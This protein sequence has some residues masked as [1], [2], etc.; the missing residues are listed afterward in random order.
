[1]DEALT[2]NLT[3]HLLQKNERLSDELLAA[4]VA[5]IDR[6]QRDPTVHPLRCG[7]DSE[8]GLLIPVAED[9][10]IV[11]LCPDCD[12]RQTRVPPAILEE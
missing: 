7:N 11:L 10:R 1:M 5:V 12:Y 2:W 8:H 9:Q 4:I 6:W 3:R